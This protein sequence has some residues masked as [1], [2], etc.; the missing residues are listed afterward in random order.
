[1]IIWVGIAAVAVTL[2]TWATGLVNNI[3]ATAPTA[4]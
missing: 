2:I 3:I 4:P 1:V